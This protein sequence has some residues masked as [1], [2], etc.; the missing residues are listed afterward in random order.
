[1][2]TSVPMRRLYD[3]MDG[4]RSGGAALV[5][6]HRIE[7]RD[8]RVDGTRNGVLADSGPQQ[9]PKQ[10]LVVLG[11]LGGVDELLDDLDEAVWVVVEWEVPGSAEHLQARA[12]HRRMGHHRMADRDYRIILTPNQ[13][14]GNGLRQITSV[15]H[16]HHLA[17]PVDNR[18]Q[19]PR[20]RRRG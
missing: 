5:G 11:R 15:E 19:R 17:A 14:H 2:D 6:T 12:G 7:H 8:A 3:V 18:P 4:P 9:R 16:G 10:V 1:T 13:L 20:E